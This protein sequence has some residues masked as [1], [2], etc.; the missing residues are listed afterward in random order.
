MNHESKCRNLHGHN[1]VAFI[2]AKVNNGKLDPVG[3][4]VDFS[5]L[6][7]RVGGWIEENWDHGFICYTKDT[8]AILAV[9]SIEGQKVFK[10]PANPTAENMAEYLLSIVGPKVLEGSGVSLCRVVLHETEN[11]KAEASL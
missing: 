11:C 7:D 5:V 3:R 8:S 4:V 1:Y 6:K 9:E 2:T 10:L